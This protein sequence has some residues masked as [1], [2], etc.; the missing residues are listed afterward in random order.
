MLRSSYLHNQA[1]DIGAVYSDLCHHAQECSV[2]HNHHR[3][4]VQRP[5]L[6]GRYTGGDLSVRA[7]VQNLGSNSSR[8]LR[9]R[10]HRL[11]RNR[12]G[13]CG[14]GLLHLTTTPG[15]HLAAANAY[16]T[17]TH[18]MRRLCCRLTVRPAQI[19]LRA[20]PQVEVY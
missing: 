12:R 20:F 6:H 14:F 10:Q 15:L 11:C 13:Q 4:L 16:Q 1:F 8:T 9:R 2:L 18:H 3:H 17:E 7:K 19:P 5:L